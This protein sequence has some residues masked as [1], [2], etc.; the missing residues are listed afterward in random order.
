MKIASLLFY[1]LLISRVNAQQWMLPEAYHD[2]VH[3]ICSMIE[4]SKKTIELFAPLLSE[5]S[6]L[7]ALENAAKKEV[8]I[9]LYLERIAPEST[10]LLQ[11][12]SVTLY[13]LQPLGKIT[14]NAA[15]SYTLLTNDRHAY[16]L[17]T[18]GLTRQIL[19]HQHAWLTCGYDQPGIPLPDT[20]T[21]KRYRIPYLD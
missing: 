19:T 12:K 9:T 13:Q 15:M 2:A 3:A 17:L 5:P 20:H 11:Y 7:R 4:S 10:A 6:V 14:K 1:L 18:T 8:E 21:L 16:C